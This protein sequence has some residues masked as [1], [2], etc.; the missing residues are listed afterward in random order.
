[1]SH[2]LPPV[3]H[4]VDEAVE[5]GSEDFTAPGPAAGARSVARERLP[6]A[7]LLQVFDSIRSQRVLVEQLDDNLPFR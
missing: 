2:P 6:R 5:G 7:L 1:M 3:Q 4:M